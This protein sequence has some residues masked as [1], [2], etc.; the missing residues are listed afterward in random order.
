MCTFESK[1]EARYNNC[2]VVGQNETFWNT[3]AGVNLNILSLASQFP[4]LGC[5]VNENL[6]NL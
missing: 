5:F 2:N 1:S 4:N 3:F 6:K